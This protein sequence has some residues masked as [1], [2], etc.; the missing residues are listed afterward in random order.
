MVNPS[1]NS[2]QN[3][4]LHTKDYLKSIGVPDIHPAT[5][6]FDPGYNWLLWQVI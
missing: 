2:V 3:G 5:S 4:R 1:L 6:P